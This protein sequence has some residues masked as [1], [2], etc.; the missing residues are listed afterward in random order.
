VRGVRIRDT[1]GRHCEVHAMHPHLIEFF[2]LYR[3]GGLKSP[4]C[5]RRAMHL[6]N[7]TRKISLR[8]F[9]RSFSTRFS[10]F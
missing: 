8:A 10:L 2:T 6:Q 3:L 1:V 9:F 4:D 5:G 7:L